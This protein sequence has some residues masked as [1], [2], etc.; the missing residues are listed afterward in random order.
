MPPFLRFSLRWLLCGAAVF[1]ACNGTDPADVNGT[2]DPADSDA[3]QGIRRYTYRIVNVF[4]HDPDAFTQGLVF[5]DGVL[6]EGTGGGDRMATNTGLPPASL[7]EIE[8]NSGRVLQQVSLDPQFFGEG[9]T[10][11]D[12]RIY[13]L[14]WQSRLGFIYDRESFT[15]DGEFEY[16]SEGWGL[17]HDGERLIMSDGTS[18]ITFRDRETFAEIGRIEVAAEG[19]LIRRLNELEYVEGEIWAN[20]FGT[21]LIA[22]ISPADGSVIGWIDLA[23]LL[24][25]RERAS[26]NVLNGIAYDSETQRIFVTG[27]LWPWLFEIELVAAD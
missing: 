14:T 23:G 16:T 12:G 18:A 1:V 21:E 26:A 15:V 7:R 11:L 6:L 25:S 20:V 10:L 17:T 2:D 9:I 4:P 19:Q 27:K 3:P 13:Q 22:R 8:L 24:T 5:D